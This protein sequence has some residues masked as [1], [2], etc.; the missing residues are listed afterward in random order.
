MLPSS[1]SKMAEAG[2]GLQLIFT[3]DEFYIKESAIFILSVQ[4]EVT[5]KQ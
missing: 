1:F 2:L 3:K 4:T 5:K